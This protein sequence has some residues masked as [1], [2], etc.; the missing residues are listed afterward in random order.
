MTESQVDS[1]A[2]GP[3]LSFT[4]PVGSATMRCGRELRQ[5]KAPQCE[6]Q[7]SNKIINFIGATVYP[8]TFIR[9]F[10][11]VPAE[12]VLGDPKPTR[13]AHCPSSLNDFLCIQHD[14][15]GASWTPVRLLRKCIWAVAR[16]DSASRSE[17][18]LGTESHLTDL[19]SIATSRARKSLIVSG[20][21]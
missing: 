14:D 21:Q 1:V 4:V 17:V 3:T 15:D 18:A 9:F 13:N 16:V 7:H 6:G 5:A 20:V 8:R 12:G 10:T 11:S 2:A 19:R